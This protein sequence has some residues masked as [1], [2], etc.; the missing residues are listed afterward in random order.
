MMPHLLPVRLEPSKCARCVRR[1][2]WRPVLLLRPWP[3][4]SAAR[5]EIGMSL[6]AT[7]QRTMTVDDLLSD[8]GWSQIV[9]TFVGFHKTPPCRELVELTWD[10]LH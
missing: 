4:A 9:Q 1:G 3:E 2:V 8:D 6:C 5:V 10:H 7:C